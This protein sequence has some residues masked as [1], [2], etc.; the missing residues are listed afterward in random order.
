MF[1]TLLL[2]VVFFLNLAEF[3]AL[4]S[5]LPLILTDLNYSLDSVALTTSLTTIGGIL[6][7]FV[8]GPAMDRL[9]PFGSLAVLYLFGVIFVGAIGVTPVESRV[10]VDDR[11]ILW[12]FLR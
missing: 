12:R 6:A 8:V 7:A 2:W 5:W 3:Y 4:Q 1:G 9:A 11:H 10:G